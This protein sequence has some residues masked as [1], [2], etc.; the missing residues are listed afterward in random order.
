MCVT[1]MFDICI[2]FFFLFCEPFFETHTFIICVN[3][4]SKIQ[5]WRTTVNRLGRWI[6]FDN[7][8]KTMNP[9]FMES[10]WWVF[11]QLFDKGLVYQGFKVGSVWFQRDNT[12]NSAYLLT[13][14]VD[15]LCS[16][17]MCICDYH[18]YYC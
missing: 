7:D 18:F 10:V 6:D 9:E 1:I 4:V 14:Y 8:Y 5:E 11:K 12:F 15:Y 2:Y 16:S 3:Y 17:R 13:P